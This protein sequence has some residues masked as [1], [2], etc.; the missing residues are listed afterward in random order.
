M[1]SPPSPSSISAKSKFDTD[2]ST[3]S[4]SAVRSTPFLLFLAA[5]VLLLSAC[6]STP[7]PSKA[8][9]QNG[10][11]AVVKVITFCT[12]FSKYK[13]ESGWGVDT[14]DDVLASRAK[15]PPQ[16]FTLSP[17]EHTVVLRRWEDIP[18]A[19]RFFPDSIEALRATTF[20]FHA[21]AG[22]EYVMRVWWEKGYL[23]DTSTET[24]IQVTPVT[25][26]AY[27]QKKKT[28]E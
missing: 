26:P 4:S 15:P 22:H 18:A 11:V 17:G 14:I 25:I 6:S 23:H 2:A 20:T 3:T 8:T 12:I 27:H 1:P 19:R 28:E 10:Q 7:T 16:K 9:P 21:E 13:S 5:C 24:V